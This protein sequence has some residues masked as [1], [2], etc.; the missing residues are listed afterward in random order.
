MTENSMKELVKDILEKRIID[1]PVV[2][3]GHSGS[4]QGVVQYGL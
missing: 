4:A 3:D 2:V 1:N